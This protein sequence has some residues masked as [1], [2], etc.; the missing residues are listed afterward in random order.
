MALATATLRP[1]TR[2]TPTLVH[3]RRRETLPCVWIMHLQLPSPPGPSSPLT[4]PFN[5]VLLEVI[6]RPPAKNSLA[7]FTVPRPPFREII[8]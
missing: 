5:L 1:H 4:T 2:Q 3:I 8:V 7:V 6:I